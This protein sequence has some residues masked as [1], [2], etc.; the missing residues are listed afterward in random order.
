MPLREGVSC[1]IKGCEFVKTHL[2]APDIIKGFLCFT[3]Y[4]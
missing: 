1:M 4:E 3:I 2:L